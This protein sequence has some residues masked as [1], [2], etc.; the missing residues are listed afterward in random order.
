MDE[1]TKDTINKLS[2]SLNNIDSRLR[3]I[4]S[5]SV[6]PAQ[7]SPPAETTGV[8]DE[9]DVDLNT[10]FSAIKAAVQH[11]KLPSSLQVPT[12][13]TGVKRSDQP[14]LNLITKVAKY[15]ET[16]LKII[17]TPLHSDASSK[18]QDLLTTLSALV[19]LLQEEHAAVVVQGTFDD[20]VAK[21]F[22]T[23]QRSSGFNQEA[24][25]NLRAAASIA[26]VYRPQRRG[27][28]TGY[29]GGRGQGG[30]YQQRGA[31]RGRRG[32]GGRGHQ[33]QSQ[34]QQDDLGTP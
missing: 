25:E 8:V 33:F 1:A 2:E 18:L 4:E 29:Q 3:A 17:Q 34:Q 30:Q 28:A 19:Q 23:L 9:G 32:F 21:F 15:A 20:N 22:R 13:K 14:L 27:Q 10:A 11:V 5:N 6:A 7:P 26:S 31:F 24:L 16:G 12:D